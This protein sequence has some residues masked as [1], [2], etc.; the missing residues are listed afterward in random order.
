MAGRDEQVLLDARAAE[1]G[2]RL[3]PVV[4]DEVEEP[5][6]GLPTAD[7]FWN[8]VDAG[9]DRDDEARF[10]RPG[11]AQALQPNCVLFGRPS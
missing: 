8:E 2:K 10:E 9:L 6:L 11:Q 7:E 1:I 5:P 4:A 3:Q